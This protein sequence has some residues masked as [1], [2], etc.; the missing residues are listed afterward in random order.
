MPRKKTTTPGA[1]G[2]KKKAPVKR[3]KSKAPSKSP[4]LE[5]LEDLPKKSL[6]KA[7]SFNVLDEE[8]GDLVEKTREA[9]HSVQ[10]RRKNQ[11]TGFCRMAD[12]QRSMIPYRHFYL[13]WALGSYGMKEG[14][15]L[16]IIG[17][18]HTGK[19]TLAFW[20]MGGA[21]HAG[22]PCYL[23]EAENK[24][25]TLDWSGRALHQNRKVA[26]LMLDRLGVDRTFS[27]E[28]MNQQ[29]M[30]WVNLIRGRIPGAKKVVPLDT[31]VLMTVDTMS[32]LMDQAQAAGFHDYGKNMDADAKKKKK[33][34]GEGSH[35][36]FSKFLHDMCDRLPYVQ[37][38]NNM[39][40]LI[41]SQQNDKVDMA[42]GASYMSAD[43]ADLYNETVRGGQAIGQN[44][45]V[46]L[47]VAYSRLVKNTNGDK[48]GFTSKMRVAKNSY[49]PKERVIE[50][51][52]LY[53]KHDDTDTLMSPSVDFDRAMCDWMA[54]NG[55]LETTVSA[56]RYSSPVLGVERVT[57]REFSRAF[58]ANTRV[59]TF[60]GRTLGIAGYDDVIDEIVEE[61]PVA[62][63]EPPPVVIEQPSKVK[64]EQ[65]ML[66]ALA[67]D[68]ESGDD[69]EYPLDVADDP[70]A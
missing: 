56:K 6:V 48:I 7:Y 29:M 32:K 65:D 1:T 62:P 19:S 70:N 36:G 14:S 64:L 43:A 38:S 49:G 10:S 5:P 11:P 33:N 21:M 39:S 16:E 26:Q 55:H 47:I 51:D 69:E 58:H 4:T 68:E 63:P 23:Q 17:K 42:G 22:V 60:L 41:V 9:L 12:I 50:Y 61:T 15:M 31:P 54:E 2:G 28:Q 37:H 46:R 57:A 66:E 40:M 67:A 45:G 3:G 24:E 20:L 44:A 27:L 13:Q 18:K 8:N 34:P 25:L 30:D 35:L 59:R 52:I 53:D